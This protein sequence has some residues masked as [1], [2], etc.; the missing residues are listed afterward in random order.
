MCLQL[1]TSSFLVRL[2]HGGVDHGGVPIKMVR[3]LYGFTGTR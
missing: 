1:G 2:D 3:S